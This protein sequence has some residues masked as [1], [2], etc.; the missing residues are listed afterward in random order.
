MITR[1]SSLT[2]DSPWEAKGVAVVQA[3]GDRK[4]TSESHVFL[5]C[6]LHVHVHVSL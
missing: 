2:P 4:V 6:V 3:I 1:V 5:H